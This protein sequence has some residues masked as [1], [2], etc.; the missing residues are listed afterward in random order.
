MSEAVAAV[1]GPEEVFPAAMRIVREEQPMG[2]Q[3]VRRSLR[4]VAE[5][6]TRDK[7]DPEVRKVAILWLAEAGNPTTDAL[8]AEVLLYRLREHAIWVPDPAHSEYIPAARLVLGTVQPDG[9]IKR[10]FHGE[11]CDGLARAFAALCLSVGIRCAVVGHAFDP[12]KNIG[13]VLIAVFDEDH[14]RKMRE[15]LYT[16]PS[17]AL[18]RGKWVYSP[19]G[20]WAKDPT[21]ERIIHLPCADCEAACDAD[22]CLVGSRAKMPPDLSTPGTYVGLELSGVEGVSAE[23]VLMD[24]GEPMTLGHL[25]EPGDAAPPVDPKQSNPFMAVDAAWASYF[26]GARDQLKASRDRMVAAYRRLRTVA[27]SYNVPLPD[28][29]IAEVPPSGPFGRIGW[30]QNDEANLQ[31]SYFIASFMI[32]VLDDVVNG[33]RKIAVTQDQRDFAIE[34]LPTDVYQLVSTGQTPSSVNPAVLVQTVDA[35]TGQ[36]ASP[37]PMNLGN[38]VWVAAGVIAVAAAVASI[39]WNIQPICGAL[40][41]VSNN[42]AR[43]VITVAGDLLVASGTATP[44]DV[45]KMNKAVTDGTAKVIGAQTGLQNARNAG[46]AGAQGSQLLWALAGLAAV[47]GLVLYATQKKGESVGASLTS[48][49]P[50]PPA[51]P[52]AALAA[53]LRRTPWRLR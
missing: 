16:E 47:V 17:P 38:P 43:V 36:P 39:A 25:G 50:A 18:H 40:E 48:R 30:T 49:Q 3:G 13:H 41:T 44:G 52:A 34:Q 11:D 4:R 42:A 19:F 46:N 37:P 12:E 9:S 35:K 22:R 6:A 5:G 24:G 32:Q 26:A 27:Q 14:W 31:S 10:I 8:R 51:T 45:S 20:K 28:P 53:A 7:D 29:P 1:G 2:E 15:W 23:M 33:K 21:R